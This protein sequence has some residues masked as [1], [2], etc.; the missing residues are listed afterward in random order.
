MSTAVHH[1]LSLS[2]SHRER[3]FEDAPELV[4]K[5]TRQ[6]AVRIKIKDRL[7]VAVGLVLVLAGLACALPTGLVIAASISH[8]L[9]FQCNM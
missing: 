2:L 8:H 4:I 5:F 7:S 9:S 1:N 3:A 6:K